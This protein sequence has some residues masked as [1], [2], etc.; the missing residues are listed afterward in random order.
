MPTTGCGTR[1]IK[2][3]LKQVA[4]LWGCLSDLAE[5]LVFEEQTQGTATQTNGANL[6]QIVRVHL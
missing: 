3:A 2:S 6:D 1:L 5:L 4:G